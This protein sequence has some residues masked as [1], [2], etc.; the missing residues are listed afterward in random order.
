VMNRLLFILVARLFAK[1]REN[2][3]LSV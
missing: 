1:R 3:A 2:L